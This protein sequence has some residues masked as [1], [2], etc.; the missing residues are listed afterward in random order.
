M[1][2][3]APPLPALLQTV[4]SAPR[5]YKYVI[6][7]TGNQPR[8]AD[9]YG[10]NARVSAALLL[11]M[12]FA[13]IAGRNVVA[14]ALV[15]VYGADWPWNPTFVGSLP[16][17]HGG[18]RPRTDLSKIA[19]P[20]KRRDT[21]EVVAELKFVFWQMMFT[22]SHQARVWDNRLAGLLPHSPVGMSEAA[23][24]HRVYG[25]LEVIRKLRNRV[26]HHEPIHRSPSLGRDL[27]RMLDLI[28]LRCTATGQ[29]V[30]KM[31][32]VSAL[33]PTKP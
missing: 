32:D 15:Q 3:A 4:I 19:G 33:L 18:Y 2:H 25:D 20:V 26:A 1:P 28:D 31:E 12:H 27:N 21:G 29:W 6:A 7:T 11:P 9:L 13:E 16:F 22:S 17:P 24:R 8:A 30:R 5:F 23:L 10:W 14:D